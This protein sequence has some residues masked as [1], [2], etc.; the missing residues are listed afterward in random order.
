MLRGALLLGLCVGLSA[1]G[2]VYRDTDVPIV[3]QSV[4]P[5]RYSGRWYEI[6]RFPV[7]FQSGCTATTAEYSVTGP[8]TL[9]VLNTCRAG[10]PDGEV[11]QVVGSAEIESPGKF[12]VQFRSVPILRAPYWVLWTDDSYDTAA[13]GVPSGK[14]G[15]ILARTPQ[16]SEE[17]WSEAV[18]VLAENG[19][20]T[21]QLIRTVQ[22]DR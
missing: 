3:A 6:A 19:Y 5:A 20:D 22:P 10:A 12:R 16:I 17:R 2:T 9:S 8:A 4:D 18:S 11:K 15:W 21:T 14:A 7:S 1:C 13:V